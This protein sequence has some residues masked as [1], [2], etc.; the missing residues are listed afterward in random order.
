[1]AMHA[2]CAGAISNRRMCNAIKS[3]KNV[4]ARLKQH[5]VAPRGPTIALAR[6][7]SEPDEPSKEP[8]S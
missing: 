1:M 3:A 5:N 8:N 7:E 6:D 2:Y 4:L